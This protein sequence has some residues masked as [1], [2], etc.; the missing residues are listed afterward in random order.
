MTLLS[1]GI[2]TAEIS[3]AAERVEK[4]VPYSRIEV[5]RAEGIQLA[6][7]KPQEP[8]A[9]R[10]HAGKVDCVVVVD[11][12]GRV[13]TDGACFARDL[14]PIVIT[15]GETDYVLQ[16]EEVT[17]IEPAQGEVANDGTIELP[18]PAQEQ[19]AIRVQ[20]PDGS[21]RWFPGL[22]DDEGKQ[23]QTTSTLRQLYPALRGETVEVIARV[24]AS[25]QLVS[26]TFGIPKAAP[27]PTFAA[28]SQEE[29][30][31]LAGRLTEGK[32][33]D[34]ART[35]KG[36]IDAARVVIDATSGTLRRSQL[37]SDVGEEL[38]DAGTTEMYPNQ[39]LV[40]AVLAPKGRVVHVAS[41]GKP[42]DTVAT[43][44]NAPSTGGIT[45]SMTARPPSPPRTGGDFE[46]VCSRFA[47]RASGDATVTVKLGTP[48]ADGSEKLGEG[49]D[50]DLFV[51]P[52]YGGA[53]RV[54][55]GAVR[56]VEHSYS[57]R[58]IAGGAGNAIV[59]NP[60][61]PASF[62]LVVGY[63]PF[64]LQTWFSDAGGRTYGRDATPWYARFAPY[65]GFGVVGPGGGT[66]VD[67]F[68][69]I[70]VGGEWEAFSN[71]SVALTWV[72]HRTA[73][74]APGL[75]VGGPAPDPGSLTTNAYHSALGVVVNFSPDLF[76]FTVNTLK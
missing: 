42:A 16:P 48:A 23:V 69:S 52:V 12:R 28:V 75:H 26:W 4:D 61:R 46:I 74:L 70:H 6:D 39:E 55:L 19:V 30:A 9:A 10:I 57:A 5:V 63:A 25:G 76:K 31:V 43:I 2:A 32:N 50:F 41:K 11:R 67:W 45:T 51:R 64:L 53:L 65:L 33:R 34:C 66:S 29:L 36:G 35:S 49:V 24:R 3:S 27:A 47:P 18:E 68:R 1:V 60:A 62:E 58:S 22:T 59:E 71:F 37:A 54:G 21:N 56:V 73:V 7:W 17:V 14:V 8:E 15:H 40:V 13:D 20:L 44:V 38:A 72:I